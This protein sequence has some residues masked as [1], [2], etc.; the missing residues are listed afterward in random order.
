T[1]VDR[2]ARVWLRFAT[3]DPHTIDAI[4]AFL[5]HKRKQFMQKW[6]KFVHKVNEMCDF[7]LI[8]YQKPC[9]QDFIHEMS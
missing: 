9:I 8:L 6:E 5:P 1:Y 2:F 4:I 7:L 3:T